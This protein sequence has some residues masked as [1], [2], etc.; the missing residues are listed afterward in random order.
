MTDKTPGK[1]YY[2]MVFVALNFEFDG[3]EYDFGCTKKKEA[4]CPRFEASK[5][6]LK[7]LSFMITYDI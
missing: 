2:G 5:F 1:P 3:D 7:D 4:D 6:V